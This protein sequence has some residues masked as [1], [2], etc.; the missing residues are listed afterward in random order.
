MSDEQD[1]ADVRRVLAGEP[2]AFAGI[3]RRWQGPLVNLAYRFCGDHAR[4]ED[5]AQD[6]FLGAYRALDRIDLSVLRRGQ[7]LWT[8]GHVAAVS[9]DVF[10]LADFL[11]QRRA[12]LGGP[13]QRVDRDP[14][15]FRIVA[16]EVA[17]QG[18]ELLGR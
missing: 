4:A 3:V 10:M 18:I 5:M 12:L 16:G 11:E 15:L 14:R 8:A 13:R 9:M 7:G 1:A 17:P 6:A 2:D